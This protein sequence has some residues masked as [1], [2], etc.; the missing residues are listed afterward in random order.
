[1]LGTRSDVRLGSWL[2]RHCLFQ[3]QF[4]ECMKWMEWHKFT[5]QVA[6]CRLTVVFAFY[7]ISRNE[8]CIRSF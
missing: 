5:I 3:S 1:M 4:C 2:G 7:S 6:A 8:G